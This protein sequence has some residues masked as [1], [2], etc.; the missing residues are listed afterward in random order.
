[1]LDRGELAPAEASF[2]QALEI[3]SRHKQPREETVRGLT[4]VLEKRARVLEDGGSLD[5]AR[6]VSG[7]VVR[8]LTEQFGG[9]HWLTVL[10][11][12]RLAERDAVAKLDADQ[13]GKAL[14]AAT[15]RT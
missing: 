2:R 7:E 1:M 10:A 15:R 13:R 5:E 9:K 11:G 6:K 3:L 12:A 14:E 4:R 8:L